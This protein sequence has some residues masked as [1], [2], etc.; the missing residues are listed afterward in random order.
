MLNKLYGWYGKR[1]VQ[2]VLAVI[3]TLALIT[4]YLTFFKSV[5]PEVSEEVK[6]ERV[7]VKS[8]KNINFENSFSSVGVVEAISEAKLQAEAGGR[9]TSVTTEV[10]KSVR[11]GA[12]LA[13]IENASERASVL[14]AQGAYEAALA[15]SASGEVSVATAQSNFESTQRS[16]ITTLG[17]TYTSV[18]TLM[19][20]IV[21]DYFTFRSGVAS[22]LSLDGQG[23]AVAINAKRTAIEPLLVSWANKKVSTTPA[24][25]AADLEISKSSAVQISEFVETLASLAQDQDTT[26]TYLQSEK[27][28]DIANITSARSSISQVLAQIESAQ[29]S[30]SNAQKALEQARLA[31][32]Q[33]LPSASAAQVKIAL[34]SLRAAQAQYEKTLVRTPISGVVN[35]LYV[36]AGE[37]VSPSQPTA[38]IANNKGLQ[39]TTSVS[40]ED[41]SLLSV[42]DTVS[43]NGFKTGTIT[44]LGGAID[45]ATGKVMVKISVDDISEI[46]NGSTVTI[47]FTQSEEVVS[48]TITVP[49]SA[50]KMTG[51]G[52]VAF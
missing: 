32:A 31:G 1:T 22:G 11:A 14:Q 20:T 18:D 40:E 24:Q 16:A 26:S 29:T 30:L 27:D 19:R 3:A 4:L 39:V 35:A 12:I 52:P 7:T 21:D 5:A 44:A 42:G 23:K 33:G 48:D 10:G 51:S 6:K 17:S 45:P 47:A 25:I 9:I 50:I 15:G 38:V 49:L 43:I 28:A 41:S 8:V 36:K 13:T 46:S 2:I 37:Y 34:G